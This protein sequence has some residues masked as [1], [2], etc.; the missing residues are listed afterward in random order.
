MTRQIRRRAI[1]E[2]SAGI[3]DVVRLAGCCPDLL[4]P[5]STVECASQLPRLPIS[6][7][8]LVPST[9]ITPHWQFH[10]T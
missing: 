6:S 3:D 5:L 2:L 10:R 9:P 1:Y 8:V 7:G 4:P